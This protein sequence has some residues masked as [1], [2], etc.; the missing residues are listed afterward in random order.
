[1][2]LLITDLDYIIEQGTGILLAR[3]FGRDEHGNRQIIL[4]EGTRPFFAVPA[5]EPIPQDP[6]ITGIEDGWADLKG[7]PLKRI[8]TRYPKDVAQRIK[9]KECNGEGEVIINGQTK[10]CGCNKGQTE[11]GLRGKFQTTFQA[12][13]VYPQVLR[14]YYGLCGEIEIPSNR[15]HITNIRKI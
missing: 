8:F 11:I 6:R 12:D 9:C 7:N 1:M 5:N 13:I 4:I 3:C 2:R 15:C 10:A 14:I